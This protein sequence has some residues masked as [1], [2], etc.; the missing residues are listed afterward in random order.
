MMECLTSAT[1][2]NNE[3]N[4]QHVTEKND[5]KYLKVGQV[6][7]SLMEAIITHVFE[8]DP[9]TVAVFEFD[10]M[11][12]AFEQDL[13][14]EEAVFETD[15][16]RQRAIDRWEELKKN[17]GW[18]EEK[19][20]SLYKYIE[21]FQWGYT[22]KRLP[23]KE[24]QDSLDCWAKSKCLFPYD[25]TVLQ[26]FIEMF[27]L[28][29]PQAQCDISAQSE[30]QSLTISTDYCISIDARHVTE[31]NDEKYLKVGQVYHSLMEAI[32]THVF[33]KDPFTVAVF[34]FD[35]MYEAF[36]RDLQEEEAVFETDAQRQRAVDRWEELKKNIGWS[37]EKD[38]S[39]YKYIEQFQWGYTEK[40]LPVK[41]L[42]DS[43]D[44]WAKSKCLFPY[45]I[46]V[47]QRFIDM[48]KKL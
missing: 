41:E 45:D 7:Y 4:G 20:Q 2:T 27:K 21:Q 30:C 44:Y 29:E 37:E 11:F 34:E 48:L 25:I 14:E 3:I 12:E 31:E 26:R 22:E 47:L 16:Q 46:T 40:R 42:Q 39:L 24:L 28:I 1:S 18:S 33:E 35:E 13:Q 15:A 32:I 38:Q 36:E 5:E 17:I 43:L 10:E 6:Y 23:V 8:K 19:D 9:F